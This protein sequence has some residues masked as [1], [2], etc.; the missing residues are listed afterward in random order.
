MSTKLALKILFSGILLRV[1]SPV[2][3][4]QVSGLA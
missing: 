4:K 1:A 2:E 3:P